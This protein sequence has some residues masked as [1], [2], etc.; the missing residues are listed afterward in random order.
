MSAI[1]QQ[2]APM[3]SE[4]GMGSEG[5]HRRSY[6]RFQYFSAQRV[7]T[8]SELESL[9]LQLSTETDAVRRRQVKVVMESTEVPEEI[10]G[11][12]LEGV[13]PLHQ[14]VPEIPAG[15]S[16]VWYGRNQLET[17][18][19]RDAS[20]RDTSQ[21]RQRL[22]AE[23][24]EVFTGLEPMAAN[25]SFVLHQNINSRHLAEACELWADSFEWSRQDVEGLI[26]LADS[27][28][29]GT[30]ISAVEHA[31]TGELVTL[32]F[33]QAQPFQIEVDGRQH[34]F[35]VFELTDLITRQDQTG[36]GSGT[37][38]ILNLIAQIARD[39]QHPVFIAECNV[40]ARTH[41]LLSRLGFTSEVRENGEMRLL[42]EHVTVGDRVEFF[43]DSDWQTLQEVLSD[44]QLATAFL[45]YARYLRD[46]VA[47]YLPAE[48]LER[49]QQQVIGGAYAQYP[50]TE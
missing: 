44:T 25:Q 2:P 20:W 50:V 32:S 12:Q 35:S 21:R 23:M 14:V 30:Y 28:E 36:Q 33:T 34:T 10:H 24:T 38:A 47:M 7:Y 41:R 15:L 22:T 45:G 39:Y 16:F 31:N 5:Y 26:A 8:Q 49:L 42:S 29:S 43:S 6:D 11:F 3:A 4:G 40:A 27:P 18:G 9:L 19:Y 1:E 48:Q 46:F 13:L 17:Q 37:L